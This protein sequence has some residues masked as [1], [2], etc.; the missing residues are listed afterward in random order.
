MLTLNGKMPYA[1]DHVY[2][3]H[4]KQKEKVVFVSAYL[5][6]YLCDSSAKLMALLRVYT[7]R[8][9][10][11]TA[12]ETHSGLMTVKAGLLAR[13]SSWLPGAEP[14]NLAAWIIKLTAVSN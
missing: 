10:P 4:T 12:S 9:A 13:I 6:V 14:A 8:L 2:A 3:K 11:N 7:A 1:L 5:P